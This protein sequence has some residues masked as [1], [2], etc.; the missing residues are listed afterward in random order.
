M[1]KPKKLT[2]GK[3]LYRGSR[4]GMNAV[5]FHKH[6][7]NK[8]RTLVL[9]AGQSTGHP[10][11]VFGGFAGKSWVDGGKY[12]KHIACRD[13]FVFTISNT[14]GDGLRKMPYANVHSPDGH[15]AFWSTR[16]NGPIFGTG[17]YHTIAVNG[18]SMDDPTFSARTSYCH[19]HKGDPYGD[20]LGRGAETFTGAE[21]FQPVEV[22]VW[23]VVPVSRK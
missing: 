4:D 14:F 10:V 20:Q 18:T 11:C 15:A 1:S 12:G 7:D 3:L 16:P 17:F 13:S 23:T 21:K 2:V 19:P 9:I 8:G 22:E 5:A 6:C